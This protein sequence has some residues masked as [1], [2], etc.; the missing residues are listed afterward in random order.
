M[1]K[2]NVETHIG[3]KNSLLLSAELAQFLLS[4]GFATSMTP[5]ENVLK[6]FVDVD[7]TPELSK[8]FVF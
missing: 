2:L 1:Y 5:R 6:A 7:T 3:L 8:V 4:K